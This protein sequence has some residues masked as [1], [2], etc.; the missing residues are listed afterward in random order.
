MPHISSGLVA[1]LLP[2]SLPH[3]NIVADNE[4]LPTHLAITFKSLSSRPSSSPP[5]HKNSFRMFGIIIVLDSRSLRQTHPG[6]VRTS[7]KLRTR[8]KNPSEAVVPGERVYHTCAK[9]QCCP[10]QKLGSYTHWKSGFARP[11]AACSW[12]TT[13]RGGGERGYIEMKKIN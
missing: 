11:V 2:S 3:E 9:D 6:P 7:T 4:P 8:Y 10:L 1:F 12:K 13:A 5:H